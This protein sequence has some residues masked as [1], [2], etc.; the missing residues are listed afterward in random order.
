MQERRF[1]SFQGIYGGESHDEWV[2]VLCTSPQADLQTLQGGA[3]E[4]YA[5][6]IRRVSTIA[7]YM[8]LFDVNVGVEGAAMLLFDPPGYTSPQYMGGGRRMDEYDPTL[9]RLLTW[10]FEKR[11]TLKK[12]MN[13]HVLIKFSLTDISTSVSMF[14][15]KPYVRYLDLDPMQAGSFRGI[16]RLSTR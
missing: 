3:I 14:P 16:C 6:Y 5:H 10:H 4:S 15:C 12:P 9:R 11:S 2:R 13:D 1:L 7:M 8:A